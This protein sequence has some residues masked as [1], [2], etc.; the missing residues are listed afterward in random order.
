MSIVRDLVPSSPASSD[1]S[2]DTAS[3]NPPLT[4]VTPVS[5][6]PIFMNF[7]GEKS[8]KVVPLLGSGAI[9]SKSSRRANT[10]EQRATH[11]AVE[12]QRRETLNGR[13]M[14]LAALLSN[15]S[16]IRRPTKSQ[17]VNSSI[18]H[19]RASDR[20]RQVAAGQLRSLKDE[21]DALR[22]ELN[23]WRARSGM[24][25]IEEPTRDET[26][27]ILLS[28]ELEFED[29]D[30][31]PVAEEEEMGSSEEQPQQKAEPAASSSPSY[32]EEEYTNAMLL[33]QQQLVQAQ[34]LAAQQAQ[35]QLA[36]LEAMHSLHTIPPDCNCSCDS[37]NC[38]TSPSP[39]FY[40][41]HSPAAPFE[42]NPV[43]CQCAECTHPP[44]HPHRDLDCAE[45]REHRSP[46]VHAGL[47]CPE[48]AQHDQRR[49]HPHPDLVALWAE[50]QR[51]GPW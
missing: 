33:Q 34:M 26:F 42:N 10:A 40:A 3:T 51:R 39:P 19:L 47:Q 22:H 6:T 25:L 46:H 43:P 37:P 44:R 32:S 41:L 48:C 15:L 16:A 14:D 35:R 12:R 31:L 17:I 27:G 50:Q 49:S 20:Q 1:G 45:C 38:S 28:G 21:A 8:R 11:N 13:F 9:R 4:P 24:A 2:S 7:T 18:A 23:A 30:M 36:E 29:S 5:S